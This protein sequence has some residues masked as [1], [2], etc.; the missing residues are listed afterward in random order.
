MQP[1]QRCSGLNQLIQPIKAACCQD[2][3]TQDMDSKEKADEHHCGKKI[4]CHIVLYVKA[5]QSMFFCVLVRGPTG[6]KL[7]NEMSIAIKRVITFIL[8][9]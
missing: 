8:T 4:I 7:L 5:G 1:Y 2:V 6:I 3:L 9:F